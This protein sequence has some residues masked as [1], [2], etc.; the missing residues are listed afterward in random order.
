MIQT[1]FQEMQFA[2]L[3]WWSNYMSH[4]MAR[5]RMYAL[6]GAR[7]MDYFWTEFEDSV[8]RTVEFG[9]GP[10]PVMFMLKTVVGAC[11][12][13]LR[14]HYSAQ[15]WTHPGLNGFLSAAPLKDESV[16]QVLLLNV[17]DHTD[18]PDRLVA[19]AKRV[20]RYGGRALVFVHLNQQDPKHS[21]VTESDVRRWFSSWTEVKSNIQVTPF[22]PDAFV[23]VF[24]K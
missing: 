11:I 12:D 2:E 5:E 24:V 1:K 8:Q 15:G 22:D 10:L 18:E 19:D 20:L 14:N 7:Y 21:L 9:S 4:P 3:A 23:G 16:D 17:L 13:P 6:Y